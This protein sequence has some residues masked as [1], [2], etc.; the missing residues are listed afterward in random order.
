MTRRHDEK[1]ARPR[2]RP[3]TPKAS[4]DALQPVLARNE[5][6]A[7]SFDE[8]A[9]ILELKDDNPFRIRAYRNAARTLRGLGN[10]V[11]DMLLQGQ[12][13]A[14][15]P[16]IGDDLAE[17]IAEMVH[18]GRLAK[19]DEIASSAPHLAL[20]LSH[21]PGIGP[22]RAMRLCKELGARDLR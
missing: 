5:D 3:D 19:L 20:E 8:V 16:G 18:T 15:L 12:D 13:L 7:R 6:V 4:N 14:E 21:L 11:G 10:E 2:S 9:E 1:N 22:K 17:Q